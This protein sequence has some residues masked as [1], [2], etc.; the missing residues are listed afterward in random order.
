[1]N[2]LDRL[3]NFNLAGNFQN[4]LLQ[5]MELGTQMRERREQKEQ[6]KALDDYYRAKMGGDANAVTS[7]TQNLSMRAPKVA[8]QLSEADRQQQVR[9]RVASGQAP[10]SELAPFDFD[11]YRALSKEQRDIYEQNIEI[12]GNL[13]L[14]ADTPEK[15][16]ATVQQLGPEFAQYANQ[17]NMREGL[18]AKAKMTKDYLAQIKPDYQAIPYDA[19]LVNVKDPAAI[20]EFGRMRG[21]RDAGQPAQAGVP[22][23]PQGAID[24]LKGNPALAD[25]FDQKY[26]AGAAQRVLGGQPGG[27]TPFSGSLNVRGVQGDRITSGY[28][29]PAR[30]AAVGGVKNSFH[31]RKGRD[32]KS[33]GEDRVPPPGMSMGRFHQILKQQNPHLDVINEGDHVHL[34]PRG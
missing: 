8:Y 31:M 5:G 28:R 30:N 3:G 11:G 22:N 19:D 9:A 10:A 32:G 16:A 14:A 4:S 34:E 13:A 1:M 6:E 15:W 21:Q 2:P 20:A 7:A 25:Q 24:M 29:S 12:I 26:G 17:F 23:V 18:I 33:L 27:A